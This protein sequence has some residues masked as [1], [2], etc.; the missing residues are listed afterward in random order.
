MGS[1][2]EGYDFFKK[3]TG[4]TYVAFEGQEYIENIAK[5]INNLSDS[6]NSMEGFKTA[7]D[8][9]KGDVAEF[10]HSGTFNI[11]AALKGSSNRTFVDRSHEFASPDI[12]SNF[13][14]SFGLKYYKTGV[15]S[16]KQQAKSISERY[17]NYKALGGHDSM[18]KFLFNRNFS[19]Q[20]APND[21]IYAG[22]IRVVPAEQLNEA[23]S[24]LEHKI[25]KES[26]ARPQEV[27]RYTDTLA[28]LRDKLSD[29][30]GQ[31][32]IPLS[33]QEA[34]ELAR[35]VKRGGF[36]PSKYGFTTEELVKYRNL[37]K[38]SFNAG[39]TAATLS[40]VLNI[41]PEIV[42]AIQYL[43]QTGELDERQFQ[44]IGFAAL[45]GGTKG[46]IQGSVSASIATVCTAGLL[47]EGLKAISPSIIAV[48]TIIATDTIK[49]AFAVAIG[50]KNNQEVANELVRE[51]FV[52]ACSLL[53]GGIVQGVMVELPVIG[54]MI[55]SLTGS[56]IGSVIYSAGY[57]AAVSFCI[58]TGFTM[59]GLVDQDYKLPEDVMR[60]I[61]LDVFD[62]EKFSYP[63]FEYDKLDIPKFQT[64]TFQPAAIGITFLRRGVIGIRK[65]A[66]I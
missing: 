3:N 56:I 40:I 63:I 46:F 14:D 57:S 24:W 31:E 28:N 62:Y 45:S 44:K 30:K 20:S 21:P 41:A 25:A 11:D 48:V 39:I 15:D 5:E 54:F 22:Q 2:Q 35:V 6:L 10:W 36:D 27:K 34:E 29:N 66:Y 9:L 23:I 42:K 65:I 43:I 19:D 17:A 50:Q 26:T 8:K 37:L 64:S 38:Q 13:N 60:E 12:T 58:D 33:S 55:G 51:M 47:G 18:E 7:S 32:S 53:V 49:N 61:G 1:F 59:F 4:T 16:A 52:S